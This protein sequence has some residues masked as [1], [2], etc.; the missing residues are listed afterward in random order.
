MIINDLNNIIY[1]ISKEAYIQPENLY[2]NFES[3]K[4]MYD[5][6]KYLIYYFQKTI[7]KDLL[8]ITSGYSDYWFHND[9]TD[10]LLT[11]YS[12]LIIDTP[13]M[14]TATTIGSKD[15]YNIRSIENRVYY[16]DSVLDIIKEN[17]L[18]N[19]TNL[20]FLAH[21]TSCLFITKYLE[22]GKHKNLTNTVVF[23][24]PF[25]DFNTTGI[26][27]IISNK[28]LPPIGL[29]FP[30][31]NININVGEDNKNTQNIIENL[32]NI[33]FLNKYKP[34]IKTV[35]RLG[36]LREII[37]YQDYL[38]NSCNIETN[39]KIYVLIS[40]KSTKDQ[41][42]TDIILNVNKLE[43]ISERLGMTVKKF[44]NANHDVFSS[45]PEVRNNAILYLKN[46]LNI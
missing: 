46:I 2:P 38:Q 45:V 25:F 28:I 36:T 27:R 23:N 24:S 19:F 42:S 6:N 22:I 20:N 12:V 17:D 29:L 39:K 37:S 32:K 15:Y 35:F 5:N 11:K 26:L 8:V 9:I 1:I 14:G 7:N 43:S 33:T 10:I 31:V 18:S 30:S 13:G 41:N 3:Y 44:E 4:I 16:I 34:S 21:S 40:D